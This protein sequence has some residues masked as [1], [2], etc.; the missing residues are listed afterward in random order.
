VSRLFATIIL[1]TNIYLNSAWAAI[2]SH[3][4]PSITQEKTY[5]ELVEELRCLVCQN[6]NLSASNSGLAKDLRQQTYN[7]VLAGKSKQQI[8]Q[9][10]TER[11]GD[12]VLYNPPVK[13]STLILWVGPFIILLIAG[14]V[15]LFN[16]K[17]SKQLLNTPIAPNE[18]QSE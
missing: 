13:Q 14:I 2:E 17:K 11:Y 6:Q 3:S 18:D 1:L 9:Y 8:T 10:M 16:L 12:F 7:M 4:F 5:H 15:L